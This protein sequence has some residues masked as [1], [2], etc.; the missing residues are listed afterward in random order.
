[1]W[2]SEP[3]HSLDIVGIFNRVMVEGIDFEL[4]VAAA[5]TWVAYE[6]L[7]PEWDHL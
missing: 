1:M 4:Q 7:H 5:D 3:A 6:N 2:L